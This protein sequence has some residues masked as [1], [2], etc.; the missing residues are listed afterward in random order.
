VKVVILCGGRGTRIQDVSQSI[1]KP[2]VRIGGRPILWHIMKIYS[3]FGFKDFVLALGHRS[4]LIKE[5]FLN[6][7]AMISDVEVRLGTG[8]ACRV[9]SENRQEDWSVTLVE[10]GNAASTGERVKRIERYVKND[11]HFMLTYGDGLANVNIASLLD[12]HQ[13]H[14]RLGTVT[15]VRPLARF[16][17]LSLS[18]TEVS[19]FAEKPQVSSGPINGGFFVFRRAFLDRLSAAG[20]PHLEREP[21]MRLAEEG[22][23]QCYEH[24]S[25]WMPMDT[26][27]EYELLNQMWEE[28]SAPWKV[29]HE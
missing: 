12:F 14:D 27:R 23:L 22:Q 18:G 6:Y 9:L 13:S 29:W 20:E 1:P 21:L 15:G 28:G 16:G 2:L 19:R 8:S 11:E 10:T 3:H 25:W 7:E 5:F 24:K 4:W 26:R 17:E